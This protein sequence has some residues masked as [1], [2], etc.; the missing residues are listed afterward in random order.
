VVV[1][2]PLQV[3]PAQETE[4]LRVTLLPCGPVR[5]IDREQEPPAQ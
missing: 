3:P 5:V 4:P 1:R 2:L